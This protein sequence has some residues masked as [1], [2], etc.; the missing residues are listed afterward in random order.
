MRRALRL[1][2]K[3]AGRTSPNPMVGAVLVKDGAVVGE[4]WHQRTGDPHAEAI[5]LERAGGRA[6]GATLYV[7]LEPCV[8]Q[9]R[10]PPCANAVV[11]AGVSRVVAALRD[12]DP[13]VDGRGLRTLRDA[14]IETESGLMEAEARRLNE[15]FI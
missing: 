7:T 2:S 8:H 14:G 12:P 15:G 5:A 9:G 6:R 1:A 3:G 13:R 4:G 10:T 11:A